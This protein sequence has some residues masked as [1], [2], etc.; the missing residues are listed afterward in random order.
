MRKNNKFFGR[1]FW[2]LVL[3]VICILMVFPF[4][5]LIS[6]SLKLEKN[7]FILPPQLIPK[8]ATFENYIA[9]LKESK[10]LTWFWNSLYI[11]VIVVLCGS[12]VS[13]MAG[14]AYAKLRFK[15]RSLLFM[16]PL[17]AIMI[18]NEVIL[19]PMFKMWAWVGSINTH[20]PLI[21]PSIVGI[22][23]MFG[24]FLFRQY[25]LSIPHD[26]YEAAILDGCTPLG[27]YFRIMLPV[28][29]SPLVCLAIFNFS[30]TWNDY[31]HP[32]IYLNSTDKYTLAL[33]LSLY[34]D[35]SGVLW[36]QLMAACT[37]ATLPIVILFF[38]AQDKFVESV[39]L[40]GM[41]T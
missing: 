40:T 2:Y 13:S 11:T 3:T 36:G 17:C 18:P 14:F 10:F 28:S 6:S 32:L 1:A 5:W 34:T 27:T 41:K 8:P 26:L 22:G 31:L 20:I 25:Y 16:L 12:F 37:M 24:V 19:I 38:I 30:A 7:I 23:G 9:A 29:Q 33:G 35:M 4:F 21:L 15:G 39:A